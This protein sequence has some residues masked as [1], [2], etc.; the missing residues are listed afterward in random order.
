[1]NKIAIESCN[2]EDYLFEEDLVIDSEHKREDNKYK[3]PA[4]LIFKVRDIIEEGVAKNIQKVE[5]KDNKFIREEEL[6]FSS[7]LEKLSKFS[8]IIKNFDIIKKKRNE[9]K[10]QKHDLVK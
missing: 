6:S 4:K 9:F 2:L 5:I 8:R 1:M 10:L 3:L 7:K